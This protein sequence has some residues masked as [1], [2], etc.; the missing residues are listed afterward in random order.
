MSQHYTAESFIG[1][2]CKKCGKEIDTEDPTMQLG[3]EPFNGVIMECE[4][5][6]CDAEY[7]LNMII[8]VSRLS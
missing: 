7:D 4:N 2:E 3:C 6:E 5:P 8:S 1:F